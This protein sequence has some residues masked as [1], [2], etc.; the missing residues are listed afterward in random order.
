MKTRKEVIHTM[1][2]A[3]YK[4]LNALSPVMND[5]N[6][7][8]GLREGLNKFLSNLYIKLNDNNKRRT[9]YIS[10]A[11]KA[12]IDNDL[13][14]SLVFEHIVPKAEY[15]Q[16]E[17]VKSC[18]AGKVPSVSEIEDR[19]NKYWKIATITKDEDDCLT[20]LGL[21]KKMPEDWDKEDTLARYKKAGINLLE[22][23]E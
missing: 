18:I 3:Y 22:E 13:E 8:N 1:A 14:D 23:N 21:S 19:L 2:E 12:R 4:L 17:F 20:K 5:E 7:Q 9:D 6:I 16:N 10:E 11:A 15:I